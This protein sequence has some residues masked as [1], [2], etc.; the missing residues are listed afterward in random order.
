MVIKMALYAIGDMHLSESVNKPMDIFGGRWQN[1]AE[2]IEKNWRAIVNDDDTVVI[3]GDISWALS[4]EEATVDLQFIDSLPG[5]KLI[6][7]GNHDFWWGTVSKM[8][9]HLED[10]GITT[11]DFLH[12]NAFELEDYI[13]CGTRGWYMDEKQQ[14]TANETDFDK[15]VSRE[16][17][18]LDLALAAALPLREATGKPILV[19]FHF[20]PV[21]RSFICRPFLDKLHKADI[22]H[23]YYGHIHGTYNIPRTAEYEGISFSLIAADFLNF[24]PMITFPLDF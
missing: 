5:K 22:K 20:P 1:H 14:N 24:V 2:K 10:N 16:A 13:V 23:C 18:R 19:Y 6:G 21:Y 8:K 15:I 3:P 17:Q 11:I 12:N 4:L 7:K 9:K